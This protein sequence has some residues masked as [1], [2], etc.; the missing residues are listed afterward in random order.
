MS[1]DSWL[2]SLKVGDAVV[3]EWGYGYKAERLT[4]VTKVTKT[5]VVVATGGRYRRDDG[6]RVGGEYHQRL[7][8][9][10]PER[11]GRIRA[12]ELADRLSNVQWGTR[13]L[14]VLE[15]VVAALEDPT[16]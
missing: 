2:E 4:T 1:E 11:R 7:R 15:R 6:R 3:E 10:T 14:A 12:K 16:P 5:L 8:Q 13:P 9:D